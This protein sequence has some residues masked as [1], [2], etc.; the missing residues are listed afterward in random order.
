MERDAMETTH[1]LLSVEC[2]ATG[3]RGL[4][5]TEVHRHAGGTVATCHGLRFPTRPRGGVWRPWRWTGKRRFYFQRHLGVGWVAL[6][7]PH[8]Q[9]APG[10]IRPPYGLR[11]APRSHR[12]LRRLW[13]QRRTGL[14]MGWHTVDLRPSDQR[15][16]CQL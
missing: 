15:P 5:A 1:N 9:R 8:D 6:V 3:A 4:L 13:R 12:L 2:V 16:Y 10:T 7:L 14:G 11:R